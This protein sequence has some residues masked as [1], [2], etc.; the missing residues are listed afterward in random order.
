MRII[1][2]NG[3]PSSGKDTAAR[4]LV[5]EIRRHSP[6]GAY[7]Y[8]FLRMSHPIKR[9][10]AG[11]VDRPIDEWGNVEEWE[12]IK[13]L[14]SELLEGTSYRQ[15]QI[16]FSEKLMKPTYG[17]DIFGRIF[18]ETLYPLYNEQWDG[19][20]IVPDCGFQV[21]S[22]CVVNLLPGVDVLLMKLKRAGT[23]FDKDSRGYVEIT[24]HYSCTVYNDGS[25]DQL[26]TKVLNIYRGW[27]GTTKTG[28]NIP[29]RPV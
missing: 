8:K 1:L 19:D 26:R 5:E 15:W 10:F 11:L 24:G 17:K 2:L 3:P 6:N 12:G 16:N 23:N 4:V 25:L 7:D 9:A 14:P 18:C 28:P 22:D 27:N 29:Q 13:D 20:V 21:E